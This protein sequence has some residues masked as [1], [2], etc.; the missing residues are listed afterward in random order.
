MTIEDALKRE[1]IDIHI[2]A[3]GLR[4]KL[5]WNGTQFA[6]SEPQAR[7]QRTRIVAACDTLPEALDALAKEEQT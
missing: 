1:D 7:S 4:R 6:V 5:F 3:P 2:V